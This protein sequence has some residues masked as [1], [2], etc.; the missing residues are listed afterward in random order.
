[1]QGGHREPR[2]EGG[3]H[4]VTGVI[5][6][7]AA[8]TAFTLIGGLAFGLLAGS[9]VFELI[10]G[11]SVDDVRLGHATIAAVPALV[12][13]FAGGAIW[14]VRMG[15]LAAATMTAAWPWR[16]CSGLGRSRWPWHLA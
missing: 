5:L 6:R 7:S 16:G 1:M 2:D 15:R 9:L 10:P 8:L 13:L 12:C 11:S 14:G 3:K 4:D